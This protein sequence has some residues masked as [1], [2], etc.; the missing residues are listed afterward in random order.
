MKGF[1]QASLSGARRG[2][3]PPRLKT[4]KKPY[5]EIYFFS[6]EGEIGEIPGSEKSWSPGSDQGDNGQ[7]PGRWN[8]ID[9]PTEVDGQLNKDQA[10]HEFCKTCTEKIDSAEPE[11]GTFLSLFRGMVPYITVSKYSDWQDQ[12]VF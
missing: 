3:I 9:E 2:Y 6:F 7:C 8:S 4:N 12:E 11:R 5:T 1:G 10:A